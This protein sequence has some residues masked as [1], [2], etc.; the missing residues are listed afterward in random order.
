VI[1]NQKQVA[2]L[3]LVDEFGVSQR[4]VC[5]VVDQYRSTQRHELVRC[6]KKDVCGNGSA[7][8]GETSSL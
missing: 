7:R 5:L 4:R 1:P 8:S 6:P 3:A 2:V